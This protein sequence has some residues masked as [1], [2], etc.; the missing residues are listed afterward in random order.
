MG[1]SSRKRRLD[2]GP[3]TVGGHPM[4]IDQQH[5]VDKVLDAAIGPL[6]RTRVCMELFSPVLLGRKSGNRDWSDSCEAKPIIAGELLERFDDVIAHGKIDVEPGER[7]TVH[8]R[9]DWKSRATLRRLVQFEGRLAD[10]KHKEVRSLV[11]CNEL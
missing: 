5:Q 8:P 4:T 2:G 9:V 7:A 3:N 11:H 6:T 10:D 1:S